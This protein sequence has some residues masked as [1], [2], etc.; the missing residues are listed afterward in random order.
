MVAVRWKTR[1]P[2]TSCRRRRRA[3]K[4]RLAEMRYHRRRWM[5]VT[6]GLPGRWARRL[7]VAR[8]LGQAAFAMVTGIA[9][10]LLLTAGI[11]FSTTSEHDPL[12]QGELLQHLAYRG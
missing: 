9:V 11:L 4:N 3:T 10:L 1:A 2:C 8:E 7:H 6:R 5:C 12:V